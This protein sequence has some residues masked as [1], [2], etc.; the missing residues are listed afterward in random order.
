MLNLAD[1]ISQRLTLPLPIEFVMS[2]IWA[3]LF[4]WGIIAL[5]RHKSYA[6]RYTGWMT[7]GWLIYRWLRVAIF[8][9]AD[10]DQHRLVFSTGLTLLIVLPLVLILIRRP[11]RSPQHK[12]D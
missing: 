6:I 11:K 9:Q 7:V 12:G 1:D 10:Y 2:L 5:I 3:G 8:A 4:S